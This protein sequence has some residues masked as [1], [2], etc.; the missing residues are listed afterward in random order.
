MTLRVV[1]TDQN[2]AVSTA[3]YAIGVLPLSRRPRGAVSVRAR[4]RR[5][6]R[7][8]SRP[9]TERHAAAPARC[10]LADVLPRT[11]RC[12]LRRQGRACASTARRITYRRSC[13][14]GSTRPSQVLG[15]H[16]GPGDRVGAVA[17]QFVHLARV[18][19][20]AERAG[21]GVGADQHAADRR[22][23]RGRSCAMRAR[24]RWSRPAATAAATISTKRWRRAAGGLAE[25]CVVFAAAD[26]V[27]A[28]RN[29]P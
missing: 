9:M 15:A 26:D 20:R 17:A 25:G 2:D 14:A 4:S 6:T 1:L 13:S 8:A 27:P 3:G 28:A 19:S 5:T 24:A 22:R 11:T 7:S 21:R 16:V 29:G 12:A 18:V 23:V 10:D